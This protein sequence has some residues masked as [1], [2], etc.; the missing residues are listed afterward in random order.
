MDMVN[1]LQNERGTVF[2]V[3]TPAE[4]SEKYGI[5]EGTLSY[6]RKITGAGP[7]YFMVGRWV[8]Y[9]DVK[10]E[11]WLK[12][13]G[14][15]HGYG[16]GKLPRVSTRRV[17]GKDQNKKKEG[18]IP[19]NYPGKVVEVADI[20]NYLPVEAKAGFFCLRLVDRIKK[21]FGRRKV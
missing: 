4:V 13:R 7:E 21:I 12:S 3:S 17:P 19:G 14:F 1:V 20:N 16:Q 6:W 15:K 8:F 11:A 2:P 5:P 9:A 10:V 18:G